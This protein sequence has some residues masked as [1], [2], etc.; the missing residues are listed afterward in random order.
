MIFNMTGQNNHHHI[1]CGLE[2]QHD[3]DSYYTY[4]NIEYR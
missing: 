2:C 4:I 1:S 3:D